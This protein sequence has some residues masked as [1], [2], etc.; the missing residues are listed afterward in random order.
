MT[1]RPSPPPPTI[2]EERLHAQL[3]RCTTLVYLVLYGAVALIALGFVLTCAVGVMRALAVRGPE[4]TG[5]ERIWAKLW[6]LPLDLH[7]SAHSADAAEVEASGCR[8]TRGCH[9]HWQVWT[10]REPVHGHV[11]LIAPPRSHKSF[12]VIMPC[13]REW[14]GSVIVNDLRG[15][16]FEHTGAAR[17][18]YGPNFGMLHRAGDHDLNRSTGAL[19]GR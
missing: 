9:S 18:S 6:R 16:L 8:M 1:R 10:L 13:L 3:V 4:R 12:G 5:L 2:G 14:P 7:G 17:E 15:E 11:S 19:A